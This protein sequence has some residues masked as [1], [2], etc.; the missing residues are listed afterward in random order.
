MGVLITIGD[1]TARFVVNHV[2]TQGRMRPFIELNVLYFPLATP[3]TG[4]DTIMREELYN[5]N[6][7]PR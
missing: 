5:W 3:C 6:R 4:R 2:L 7:S 1:E